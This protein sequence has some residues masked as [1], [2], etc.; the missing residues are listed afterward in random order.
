MNT[1]IR[2]CFITCLFS[3]TVYANHI[4]VLK[5]EVNLNDPKT[6]KTLTV[7]AYAFLEGSSAE[8]SSTRWIGL[9]PYENELMF[10]SI[11]K[12]YIDFPV[13][14]IISTQQTFKVFIDPTAQEPIID[15]QTTNGDHSSLIAMEVTFDTDM[16]IF[17]N[18]LIL[19]AEGNV[20]T[21]TA[22]IEKNTHNKIDEI[23]SKVIDC[24]SSCYIECD[25]LEK[26]E[27]L[28][29]AKRLPATPVNL[30]GKLKFIPLQAIQAML[31]QALAEEAKKQQSAA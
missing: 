12:E 25:D 30:T 20:K 11:E 4:T 24:G 31:E 21:I 8:T 15:P 5:K 22:F 17:R 1:L 14:K 6:Q 9:F 16:Q 19:I 23:I 13:T 28:M 26:F 2:S 7:A 3:I 27:A 29:Q 18:L 10:F